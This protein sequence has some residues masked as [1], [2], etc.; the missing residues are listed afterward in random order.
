MT[1]GGSSYAS[2]KGLPSLVEPPIEV[3][4]SK[5][6]GSKFSL[7]VAAA[8]RAREINEYYNGMGTGHGVIIPPQV[9]S[10]S[11]KSLTVALEELYEGRLTV[12]RLSPEEVEEEAR[13]AERDA[14]EA[15]AKTDSA[16][17][18]SFTEA[19]KNA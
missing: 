5:V 11:N 17:L 2:T 9:N 19:L 10:L 1:R 15:A 4:L 8:S 7:V 16:E 12:R 13:Q 6:G 18:D 3:L 14:T